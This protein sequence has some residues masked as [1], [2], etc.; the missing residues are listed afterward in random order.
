MTH[1]LHLHHP[2]TP[3]EFIEQLIYNTSQQDLNATRSFNEV[4]TELINE[5]DHSALINWFTDSENEEAILSTFDK[6]STKLNTSPEDKMTPE[7]I[8]QIVATSLYA[9]VNESYQ[10]TSLQYIETSRVLAGQAAELTKL[11]GIIYQKDG[12]FQNF[13]VTS[14]F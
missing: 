5:A 3:P 8:R 11:S 7:D 13:R 10:K 1:E 4:V 2:L 9:V 12:D 6:I 14:I